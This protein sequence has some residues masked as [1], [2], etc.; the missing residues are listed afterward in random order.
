M[1]DSRQ[2]AMPP[3]IWLSSAVVQYMHSLEKTSRPSEK[4]L[5]EIM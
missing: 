4:D 1:S 2:I 5:P 3:G